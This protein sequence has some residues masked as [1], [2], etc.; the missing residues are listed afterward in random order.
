[1]RSIS[2]NEYVTVARDQSLH[3]SEQGA[4]FAEP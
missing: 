1:V 3:L 4:P 2:E